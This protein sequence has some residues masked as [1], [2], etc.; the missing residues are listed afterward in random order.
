MLRTKIVCTIGPASREPGILARLIQ[1]GMSVARLNMSHGELEYHAES[2]QRIRNAAHQVGTAVAI[3]IDLQGPK[4]RVGQIAGDGVLLQS[5]QPV[6]LTTEDI[7]ATS[8]RVPVQFKRLPIAV[9]PGHRI[10]LDD[11]LL[12][13]VVEAVEDSDVVC[14][15]VTGGVLTSNKGMN[16]PQAD[17]SIPAITDKDIHH[18]R[19][20]LEQRADW[21]ALSFVRRAEEVL[22]LKDMI[23]ELSPFGRATPVIAKI[24]KPEAVDNIDSIIAAADGIMVARGDLGIEAS[25]EAVPM[26]QKKI[27]AECNQVG[28]PVITATQMLDSMIRNPRPTRAEASDVANAILDG[29]DA[30][31]LSGETAVGK[32]PVEAVQTMA[33]IAQQVEGQIKPRLAL[34]A[35]AASYSISDAVCHAATDTVHM[36]GAS[37][38]LAPT[39]GGATARKLAQFR[40]SC[41]IIAITPSPVVQHELALYWGVHPL[42]SRRAPDTDSV[43]EDAVMT[44]QGAGL[45]HEGETV[46]ITAGA[47][48]RLP[49]A[50]DLIKVYTLART[51]VHGQGVGKQ[52]VLGRVRRLEGPLGEDVQVSYDEI[53]VTSKTDRSFV[54]ALRSAAGLISAEGGEESHCYLLALEIGIPA[55]VGAD[56]HDSLTDGQW[57]V[58]DAERGV[59]SERPV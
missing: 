10:L 4:L 59:V 40:P 11:G 35:G 23:R 22:K 8:E 38:I 6:R 52:V 3:L 55:V 44:A 58:L 12:D 21:V 16:L 27:I 2:I 1:A 43:I 7:T 47:I 57:I 48:G 30:I 20:A 49:G 13:L 41:P 42:L 32:Y 24:E 34:P 53:V 39:V 46:V 15:V 18:L 33:R 17:L 5:G 26:M 28:A 36:L 14:R 31:M 51:L 37:A 50:T 45:I 54:R 9:R 25:P 29:T 19:F 56:K